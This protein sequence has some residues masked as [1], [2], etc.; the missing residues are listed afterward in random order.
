[1]NESIV[2]VGGGVAAARAIE[3]I[4]EAG[5]DAPIVLVAAEEHLPYEKPPLS[6]GTLAGD[7]PLESAILHPSE[8]YAER[9]V[10]L[11]LGTTA[12][13]IDP[14]RHTVTH[15]R[16]DDLAF[17]QLLL[18]TGSSPRRLDVP[19]ADLGNVV[20]L[21]SM[22]ESAALRERL[23][24][25]GR[26][27]LVGAGWI[28][29]EVAAAARTHG[30]EVTV[31]EPQPTPLYGVLG[32]ELGHWFTG[33]HESNGVTFHFDD[34]VAELLG[35]AEVSAVV[36]TSGERIEADTVVVGVGIAPNVGLA[37]AAGLEVD[38]GILCDAALRTSHPDVFAAGDVANW[39]NPT[40]GRRIRVDHW[41]NANDG[42]FA[43]GQSMA[44][45]EVSYGPVPF[46]FSDQ[47]DVGL[48]YAGHVPRDTDTSLVFRGDHAGKEFLAF[49]HTGGVVLAG[50]HVN[51]W[52]T[53]DDVQA[54]IRA[55]APVD[56]SRLADPGVPLSDLLG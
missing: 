14:D 25:G 20:S 37:E 56:L 27:V 11:L 15:D 18:A 54:L 53:I 39:F 4:R 32:P 43:A 3:G 24:T 44:G 26:V 12:T 21:R 31:V 5:S 23:V 16:G 48:E 19:G 50:M 9:D 13:S 52:D 38:N 29:L 1:M 41:A 42:G 35:D 40:L 45:V 22:D 8:W 6:K 47:Y 7:D 49:W 17:R 34:G 2:I 36:T 10:R 51:V 30:C 46:F 55:G 33:L 28:G